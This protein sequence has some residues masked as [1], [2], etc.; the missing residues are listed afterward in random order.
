MA[1]SDWKRSLKDFIGGTVGGI[2]KVLIGQPF[3]IVKV[4]LASSNGNVGALQT[5][6]Q[7]TKTEGVLSF[8]KGSLPPLAGIGASVSIQ[9]GVL[10]YSKRTLMKYNNSK[11]ISTLQGCIAGSLAGIANSI[12]SAPAEHLR[13]KMQVQGK[14]HPRGDPLYKSSIDCASKIYAEYGVSGIYRAYLT[15]ILRDACTFATYFGTYE[16]LVKKLKPEGGRVEDVAAW[17]LMIAGGLSGYAYWAPWYPIDAVK[18]KLQADSLANPRYK[19][20]LD[21]IRQTFANEGLS[22]FYRGFVPCMLRAFPVNA[23]VFCA[24]ELT[25][26][27]LGRH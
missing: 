6:I 13:I 23:C 3:D 2:V 1:D 26:R 14:V 25:M 5:A 15:T 9:F 27:A 12:V 7:I 4:R 11:E 20:F 17:K 22:G 24:F 21:C 19:N 18:S 8:W 10:E 16:Y